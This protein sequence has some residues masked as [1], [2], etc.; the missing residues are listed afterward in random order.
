[1]NKYTLKHLKVTKNTK[2]FCASPP[3]S[4]GLR[5]T[6]NDGSEIIMVVGKDFSTLFECSKS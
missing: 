2:K 1:M 6:L 4:V 5:T 3:S